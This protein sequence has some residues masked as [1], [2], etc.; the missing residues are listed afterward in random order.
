MDFLNSN[1]LLRIF[2]IFLSTISLLIMIGWWLEI[3]FIVSP[4]DSVKINTAFC[5][6]L[7]GVL[8]YL[9]DDNEKFKSIKKVVI[10]LVL[11]VATTSLIESIKGVDLGIDTLFILNSNTQFHLM[12]Q[13]T[14]VCFTL[15]VFAIALLESSH[16]DKFSL[17]KTFFQL[18]GFISLA[19]LISH[20]LSLTLEAKT[21]FLSTMSIITSMLFLS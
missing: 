18:L 9:H 21:D 10:A 1:K 11:I 2:G 13:A 17:A 14:A 7:I 20:L 5:F 4:T 6:L 3:D 19:S 15:A 16:K 12:S 8:A